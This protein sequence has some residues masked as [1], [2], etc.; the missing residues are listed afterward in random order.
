M[1]GEPVYDPERLMLEL[2]SFLAERGILETEESPERLALVVDRR[3]GQEPYR[4]I[5]SWSLSSP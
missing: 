4:V 2:Q 3:P 1:R 5:A